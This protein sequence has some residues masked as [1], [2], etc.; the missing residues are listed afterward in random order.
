LGIDLIAYVPA[1]FILAFRNGLCNGRFMYESHM[2]IMR[3]WPG[4]E[5][6]LARD[7]G[8]KANTVFKWKNYGRIP[9]E[10]WPAVVSKASEVGMNDVTLEMLARLNPPRKRPA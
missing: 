3:K 7:I 9:S 4:G 2:D 8:Q 5:A 6:Q 1:C 10:H